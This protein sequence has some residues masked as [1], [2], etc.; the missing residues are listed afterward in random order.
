MRT[1]HSQGPGRDAIGRLVQAA[2][3]HRWLLAVAVLA[4]VLLGYGWAA[5]QPKVYEAVSQVRMTYR[6]PDL[7]PPVP[8]REE[9]PRLLSSSA[10]LQRAVTLSG[11]RVSAQTLRQRLNVEIVQDTTESPN[12]MEW[13][14][15]RIIRIG[16]VEA[17]PK[18]A[19][20]LA[21][22]VSL[23]SQQ[24]IADQRAEVRQ[25]QAA[26]PGK[27]V[28]PKPLATT[29][30]GGLLGLVVGAGLAWRRSRP[31]PEPSP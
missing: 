5:R 18:G 1:F 11:S 31:S 19:A 22:A 16:V 15:I 6:C 30:I 8:P 29:A 27:L 25:E 24:I 26:L 28:H 23:A 3:R 13:A 9:A 2:R 4:G 12:L 17:T 21:N 10:V 20:Q 14:T 7:C